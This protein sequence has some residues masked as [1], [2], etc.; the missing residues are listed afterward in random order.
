MCGSSRKL[1]LSGQHLSDAGEQVVQ[2][3]RKGKQFARHVFVSDRLER[4][5]REFVPTGGDCFQR[6]YRAAHGKHDG[7][8]RGKNECDQQPNHDSQFL[9]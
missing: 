7:Q 1:P 6:A 2:R 3:R 4:G 8:S 9:R 5:V